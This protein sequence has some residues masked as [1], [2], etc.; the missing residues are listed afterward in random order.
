MQ[1]LLRVSSHRTGINTFFFSS[2]NPIRILCDLSLLRPV[3]AS[4]LKKC[5]FRLTWWLEHKGLLPFTQFGFRRGKSC[6]DNLS[7]LH[8]IIFKSFQEKK[9]T[10]VL[11]L[12]IQSAYDNVL[13]KVLLDK[14]SHL[15]LPPKFL[16]FVS[17]MTSCRQIVC[18]YGDLDVSRVVYRGLPQD[19][20]LSPTLY[21]L[22]VSDPE[23]Y[24]IPGCKI[25]QYADDVVLFSEEYLV[26]VGLQRIE[27]T[28]NNIRST[29]DGLGLNLSVSKSNL[30]I[31]S[32]KDKEIKYSSRFG[33]RT[34]YYRRNFQITIGNTLVSNTTSAN[35]L[36]L[37]LQSSL[38]W[39][40]QINKIVATCQCPL[41]IVKYA[42]GIRGGRQTRDYYS[43]FIKLSYDPD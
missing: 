27:I 19:S 23:Q 8:S 10:S 35:F 12:D 3:F 7:I 33:S 21:N 14:L 6:L 1:F 9:A 11:F 5:C 34:V 36:G 37:I 15:G 43:L 32:P 2:Q 25:L 16:A 30:C 13:S 29:L 40:R 26:R 42:F 4:C 22:Y 18:R 38:T 24:C 17:N 20:V 41:K 28:A 31:F 39:G